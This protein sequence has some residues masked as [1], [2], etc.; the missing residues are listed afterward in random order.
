MGNSGREL[1]VGLA[2]LS[3][4]LLSPA[5]WA[6]DWGTPGLDLTHTRLTAERSGSQFGEAAW[7]TAPAGW[8]LASPV[9][10][11][12][13]VVTANLEGV[14]TALRADTGE[15]VWKVSLGTTVQ[16]TPAV[17]RGRVFVPTVSNVLYALRLIDGAPLWKRD[18]GG[19]TL[20]SPTP[21][22]ADIIVAPGF[23]L[24]HV[25]RLSGETGA[26][27]WQSPAAMWQFSNTSPAVGGGLAVFGS[28]QG[29]YYAFDATTGALRWEYIG[30][31]TVHL[32]APIIVGDRVYMAGGDQSHRVHAVDLATGKGVTGWPI[33]LPTPAP[34]IAGTRQTGWRA[35]SSFASVGGVLV[36]QTRLD[37]ALGTRAPF[38]WLSRE[39]ALALNPA[40]GAVVWQREMGRAQFTDVN[41]V[42]KFYVCPTPAGYTTDT[43]AP[44]VAVASSLK[45]V[46]TVLDVVGG[47]ESAR[48]TVAGPALASPVLANGRLYATSLAGM[49]QAFGSTVNHAPAAPTPAR[50]ADPIDLANL[51][52]S[53][54]AAVDTDGDTADY[55]LRIDADGEILQSWQHQL[56][57]AA[58]V[59][60][61][62]ITAPLVAG[63]AYTFA[64]RAR[65]PRG[66]MS[67][68]SALGMFTTTGTAGGGSTGTV[69]MPG[70]MTMPG[71][72]MMGAVMS[73]GMGTV[74][75]TTILQPTPTTGQP[76]PDK[77]ADQTAG[78]GGCSMGG[79]TGGGSV[80]T[81]IAAALLVVGRRRKASS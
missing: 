31:G 65:D 58:G 33:T 69:A 17:A 10:A 25:V 36:F 7:M 9:V 4:G 61:A 8:V 42:P 30:D 23:P 79:A 55:E 67:P 64:V 59:T 51:T 78:A 22:D 15:E 48:R 29:R 37:D 41:E 26:L 73:G 18:I 44:L 75:T 27:V 21:V 60:S 77:A 68:W 46:V 20:S 1:G 6:N 35:V 74:P 53:W 49:T 40:T 54:S 63:T 70:G 76:Q 28:Q 45:A 43:G 19:M 71:G 62:R 72:T 16:G 56:I 81:I 3:V 34:D 24:M 80:A 50:Y 5:A 52:L 38:T 32:A 57:V 12:G 47:Y 39:F 11:D 13:F 2:I 66:A 14:V